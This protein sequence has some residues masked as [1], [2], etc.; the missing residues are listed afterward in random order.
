[1]TV[2]D[3]LDFVLL[4]KGKTTFVGYSDLQIAKMI[5][6]GLEN[7]SIWYA[8]ENNNIT[9]MILVEFRTHDGVMDITE[10]LAM[11]LSNLKAFARRA[12]K[13]FPQYRIEAMRHGSKR[14]F[15]TEKLYNKLN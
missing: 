6:D 5:K 7:F 11:T 12:R 4:N 15:N 14:I 10:N 8:H 2:G 9:G 3:L 13:E 1:M